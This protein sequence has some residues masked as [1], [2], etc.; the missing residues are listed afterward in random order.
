M[1]PQELPVSI[2]NGRFSESLFPLAGKMC[3]SHKEH[4]TSQLLG[5]K[6]KS[7]NDH[8]E[9]K[10]TFTVRPKDSLVE[11]VSVP[12]ICAC[13][14]AKSLQSYPTLCD[15]MDCKPARIFCPWDSPGKNTRGSCH[16][17]LQRIFPTQGWNPAL[18]VDSLPLSYRGSYRQQ[19]LNRNFISQDW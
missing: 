14:C 9:F 11:V 13:M 5:N 17:L 12:F 18:Q 3:R 19:K 10:T 8:F 7:T 6:W 1:L 4:T 2:K 16:A 15:P